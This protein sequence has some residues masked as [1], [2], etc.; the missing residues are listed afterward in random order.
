ME[1]IRHPHKLLV[2]GVFGGRV[3]ERE[4]IDMRSD[5]VT[6]PSSAMRLAMAEAQ[7]GN[8][9]W[10]E[11]PTVNEL[12][13]RFA[14]IFGKEA[15]LFVPSG[16]MGNQLGIRSLAPAGSEVIVER[17]SH[18]F[19]YE[20]A[21]AA[22]L[23][24][25]QFLPLPGQRGILSSADVCEAIRP[26]ATQFPQTSLICLENTHNTGG[27]SVYP[28]QEIAGIAEV[29]QQAHVKMHLDG[30]RLFNA[31]IASGIPV[32]GYARHFDT[33][34]TCL[35]KSLGCPVG[36][37]LIGSADTIDIARRYRRM[38][39]G[40]MRQAGILAAA[41]LYALDHN[42]DRLKYDHENARLFAQALATFGMIDVWPVET[43][44]VIFD[45]SKSRL[46]PEAVVEA[47]TTHGVLIA[48]YNPPFLRAVMHLDV[49][50]EAVLYAIEV[51]TELFCQR[52]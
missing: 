19:N 36:S 29:A 2:A 1:D 11:D 6:K 52:G 24:G 18:I 16:T 41:G 50:R 40:S 7:V 8:D 30:A 48:P 44:I 45:V 15:A 46:T 12:Q 39:G 49:S 32:A 13:R 26:R 51:C 42:I 10:G 37:L 47:L 33:V 35:S 23:S 25:V 20:A 31:S 22:A 3:D 5:V 34:M 38:Y 43:N 27:G 9:G 4:Y 28:L 21:S 14:E 17:N